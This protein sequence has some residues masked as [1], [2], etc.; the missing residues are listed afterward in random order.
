VHEVAARFVGRERIGPALI[1][2]CLRVSGPVSRIQRRAHARVDVSVQIELA[3][4]DEVLRP[5]RPAGV[6]LLR[7]TTVNLSEGGVLAILDGE[8]PV[9]GAAAIARFTLSGEP[10]VLTGRVVRVRPA[11]RPGRAGGPLGVAVAVAFD[12]PDVH[13]DRL[14]PLLFARQ[15]NARR[16]GVL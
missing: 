6:S 2:W 10:F 14:R 8:A 11:P 3:V 12:T 1:G 13:G 15:L 4:P 9:T 5:G 7:G 16:I